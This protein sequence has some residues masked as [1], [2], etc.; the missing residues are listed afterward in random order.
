MKITIQKWTTVAVL[1]A[2]A[3][4]AAGTSLFALGAQAQNEERAVTGAIIST[5]VPEIGFAESVLSRTANE[6]SSH[7]RGFVLTEF[8]AD[9]TLG[10]DVEVTIVRSGTADELI[11]SSTHGQAPIGRSRP[12]LGAI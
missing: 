12:S 5:T 7:S 8:N 4:L 1:A 2:T 9:A 11:W 10:N 6:A 3:L